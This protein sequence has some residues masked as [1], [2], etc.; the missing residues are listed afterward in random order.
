MSK[1]HSLPTSPER[2][3]GP[4]VTT[5]SGQAATSRSPSP[6]RDSLPRRKRRLSPRRVRS[7]VTIGQSWQAPD[8]SEWRVAQVWRKDG[9]VLLERPGGREQRSVTFGE[10]GSYALEVER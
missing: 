6:S 4:T 9:L 1:Q 5:R 3:P 2:G 10:L 8:A 7:L